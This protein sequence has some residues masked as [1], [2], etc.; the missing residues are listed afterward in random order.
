MATGS[1][2]SPILGHAAQCGDERKF[3]FVYGALVA[4]ELPCEGRMGELCGLPNVSY[5]PVLSKPSPECGWPAEPSRVTT[6]VRRRIGDGAPMTPT[7]A[8]KPDMCDAVIALLEARGIPEEPIF[9][10]KFFPAVGTITPR[11]WSR[12]S[13]DLPG[14]T[15]ATHRS[16]HH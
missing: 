5:C 7:S 3:T 9:S 1:G 15:Y 8:D 13:I 14:S 12:G 4:A 16:I 11:R 2:I 10:D 6:E